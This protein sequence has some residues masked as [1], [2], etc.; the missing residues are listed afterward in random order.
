[1]GDCNMFIITD[2]GIIAREL[3]KPMTIAELAALAAFVFML[4]IICL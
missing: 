1:M 4:A 2:L 3:L